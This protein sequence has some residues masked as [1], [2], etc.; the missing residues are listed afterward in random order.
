MPAETVL[1]TGA[2]GYV[3]THVVDAFLKAG[4]AVRG[5]VRSEQTAEKVCRTFPQYADKLSF[6]I[7]P[8][9]GAPHAFDE[10]AKGVR[11]V[12]H[13]ATPF[14]IEVEDNERDLLQPAIEG[15]N[16]LLDAVKKNAPE[17]RRIVITSS[18]AAIIDLSKG[19]RPGHV[20]TEADWNPLTYEEAA[21]KETPGTAAYTAAKTLA[22]RA[23]WDFVEREKPSFDVATICPPMVYGPNTNATANLAK[24]NTSSAD[25]YRL[26][27]PNSKPSDPIP[28]NALWSWVDVRDVAE[29]HLKAYQLPEASGQRFFI[30][31]GNFSYQQIADILR[32]KVPEIKDRVPLGKPGSGLGGVELY[33]V[34]NS[35]S[36]KVLGLKYH[37]LEDTIVDSARGFLE[38]EKSA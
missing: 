1:I 31:R 36:Q 37:N 33:G 21:K 32:E 25:I 19:T 2:S 15:T 18:F 29:A 5:T 27:S 3:A 38:L 11:G 6:A 23:A 13:T 34:D 12:I 35:K 24:L 8:D 10:A 26:M 22:E 17:V 4:Y 7:V 16:N 20:Y 9:I 28:S 30:V 14:Q